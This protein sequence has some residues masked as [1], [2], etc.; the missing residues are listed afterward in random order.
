MVGIDRTWLRPGP[1]IGEHVCVPDHIL[2]AKVMLVLQFKG[3]LAVNRFD[4]LPKSSK[5]VR[6]WYVYQNSSFNAKN[7]PVAGIRMIK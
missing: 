4:E 2:P 5:T 1:L 7:L 6:K 3:D